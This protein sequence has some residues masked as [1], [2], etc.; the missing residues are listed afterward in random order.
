MGFFPILWMVFSWDMLQASHLGNLLDLD[1]LKT[2]CL[3]KE[4]QV[5]H[6]PSDHRW[7]HRHPH[8]LVCQQVY[9]IHFMPLQ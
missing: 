2:S 1:V 6:L 7:K 4:N 8:I 3:G 5:S 9:Q